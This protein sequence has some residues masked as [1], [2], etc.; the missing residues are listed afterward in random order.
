MEHVILVEKYRP[1]RIADCIL[2]DTIKNFFQ[3]IVNTGIVPNMILTGKP[4]TGKTTAAMAMCDELQYEYILINAS[5]NGNIDTLRTEIRQFASAMSFTGDRKVV[6]LD[7]ADHLNPQSTQPA[8][9]GFIEEFASNVSFIFTCNTL[10]KLLE[11]LHS[12]VSVIEYT[13]PAAEKEVMAKQM[14]KRLK[15]ILDTEGVE[16]EPKVLAALIMKFWPDF[17]RTINE[18]QRHVISGKIDE[19]ILSQVRDVPMAELI[20]AVRS[21]DFPAVRKW[22]AAHFDADAAK[23]I[24]KV[25][26]ALYEIFMPQSIPDAVVLC[27]TYLYRSAFVQDQEL[28]LAAFLTELMLNCEVKKV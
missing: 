22:C 20:K 2:P 16:Y 7:E 8:L 23:V 12:R 6:I 11:A 17:R 25:Y 10:S 24:R 14:L 3:Q 28:H 4:G 9:R 18:L 13:I 15:V 1:H 19:S 27:G 21:D 26:D 5:E